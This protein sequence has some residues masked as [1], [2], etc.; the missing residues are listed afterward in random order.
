VLD[1]PHYIE[2]IDMKTTRPSKPNN[3]QTSRDAAKFMAGRST[4]TSK[5]STASDKQT[6]GFY[7][8][9]NGTTTIYVSNLRFTRNEKDVKDLFGKYG[10]VNFVNIVL[11]RETGNSKGFAF[12]QMPNPKSASMAI[13]K[14]NGKI[15][16]GRT[17]KV[18][19]A[20]ERDPENA[21]STK[22]PFQ[23][24]RMR[25]ESETAT[26]VPAK[27]T[28]RRRDKKPNLKTLFTYLGK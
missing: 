28:V 12:V 24:K 10:V 19:V 6:T 20:Q 1:W 7:Q 8:R 14:L 13:E 9:H 15:I 16:D 3:K 17:L 2:E 23:T 25:V 21:V 4:G 5:K 22:K 18:S 11:D 26:S 27:P